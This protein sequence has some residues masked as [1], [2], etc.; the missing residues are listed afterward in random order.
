[1]N[2]ASNKQDRFTKCYAIAP[3]VSAFC[4]TITLRE[5]ISDMAN[6]HFGQCSSCV[7]FI[8]TFP[9]LI[10]DR[11]YSLTGTSIDFT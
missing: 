3:M 7:G 9:L 11:S 5:C 8:R 6:S 2:E 1:M 10:P 4:Y